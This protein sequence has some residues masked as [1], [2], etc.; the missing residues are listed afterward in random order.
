MQPNRKVS[1]TRSRHTDTATDRVVGRAAASVPA[2]TRQII[3]WIGCMRQAD[4]DQHRWISGVFI[5]G[6][7][8]QTSA[9]SKTAS[10]SP[11][12]NTSN[13]IAG[14]AASG[15]ITATQEWLMTGAAVGWVIVLL[16]VMVGFA[17]VRLTGVVHRRDKTPEQRWW[18]QYRQRGRPN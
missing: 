7:I 14:Q 11:V 10:I 6:W 3:R 4:L 1:G 2:G 12:P 13:A 18:R 8:V 9:R 17:A 5:H 15:E 16:L